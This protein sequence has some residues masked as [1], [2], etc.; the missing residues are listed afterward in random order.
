VKVVISLNTSW[1]IFNFRSGIVKQLINEG[2]EV[3]TIAPYDDSVVKLEELGCTC[4]DIKLENSGM[5][6]INDYKYYNELLKSLE[7]ITPDV[8]LSYTIK[9][10]IYGSIACNRL[11]IPIINNV[12]GLGTAFLWNKA[13]KKLIQG[14]YKYAFKSSDHIFFQNKY[15]RQLFLDEVK[16]SCERTSVL[17]GSGVDTKKFIP[18]EIGN[19]RDKFVF[20]MI[21]RL[22][23]DKGIGE[24]CEAAKKIKEEGN[25]AVF[26]ILG[27]PE[28]SHKRGFSKDR[29]DELSS[30]GIIEYLGTTTDVRPIINQADCIVLPSYREGTSKTLLEAASMGKPIIASDVPGC[31]N[32]VEHGY[33]GL[34]CEVRSC[35]S[36]AIACKEMIYMDAKDFSKFG[37][38]S[39]EKVLKEFDEQFVIDRYFEKVEH[40][41]F[42]KV[43]KNVVK[44]EVLI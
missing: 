42:M 39:R 40:I 32:V 34:L 21:S 10:N 44:E 43:K 2:H 7:I 9:P 6:V 15:D 28:E 20:L 4:H 33:N 17:P 8:V 25:E 12:S 36:L 16:I 19:K 23:I 24:F 38:N 11:N 27:K 35:E 5:N 26:Q 3:H 1:N 18:T 29:I 14:L 41:T 13:L 30:L 31:N 37:K 22:L